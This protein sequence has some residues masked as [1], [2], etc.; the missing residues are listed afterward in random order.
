[1]H[2][3]RTCEAADLGLGKG[4][5]YVAGT[6]PARPRLAVVGSRAALRHI[7]A[8]VP[9]IVEV[10]AARG[11]SIVSGGA[12]G[13]DGDAH[14][15]ALARDVAQMAILPCGPDRLYPP[16]HAGLFASMV[17]AHGALLFPHP[18]RTPSARGMFASR[19][20]LVVDASDA[21]L[22]VQAQVRS[23]TMHTG[24]LALRRGVPLGVVLGT[25]GCAVLVGRG[26]VPL[27]DTP[28][29]PPSVRRDL[30]PWLDAVLSGET[31]V[32]RAPKWPEHLAWLRDVMVRHAD[33]GTTL[34][35]L[36]DPFRGTIALTEAETL[37]LIVET[38]PGRYTPRA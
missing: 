14:R 9:T 10:A 31:A 18:P 12:L 30:E 23:G 27:G 5:V 20:R 17:A 35:D 6:V 25:P 2:P 4:I 36:P 21:V 19:N 37:G 38:H 3:V 33:A 7:R 24:S 22:V 34:D 8:V 32:A 16:D 29:T 28:P 13:I 15:A 1:M 26:G 11:F